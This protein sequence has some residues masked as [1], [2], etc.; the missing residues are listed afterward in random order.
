[1]IDHLFIQ[2]V[3]S[4]WSRANFPPTELDA[5]FRAVEAIFRTNRG[6]LAVRLRFA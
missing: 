2:K 1:M 6:F 3:A 5:M 4:A